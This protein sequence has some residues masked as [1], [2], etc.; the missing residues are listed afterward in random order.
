MLLPSLQKMAFKRLQ[1]DFVLESTCRCKVVLVPLVVYIHAN[2]VKPP[3]GE[4]PLR[5]LV[6]IF[7][8]MNLE[9]LG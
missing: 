1:A 3:D 2:T 8:V 9:V 4:E 7:L 6:T 5:K